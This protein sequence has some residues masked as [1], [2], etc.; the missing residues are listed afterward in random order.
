MPNLQNSNN[1]VL[2]LPAVVH[3]KQTTSGKAFQL[4]LILS[5]QSE[6]KRLHYIFI[7]IDQT[8]RGSSHP[9]RRAVS[10]IAD[11]KCSCRCAAIV[12]RWDHK[13]NNISEDKRAHECSILTRRLYTYIISIRMAL[14]SL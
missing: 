11:A 3:G 2:L 14:L 8:A 9:A 12:K 13:R 4:S 1:V 6:Q 5:L 7:Q 10:P